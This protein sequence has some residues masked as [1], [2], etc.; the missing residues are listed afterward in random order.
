MAGAVNIILPLVFIFLIYTGAIL[1]IYFT[2]FYN[3]DHV[4]YQKC[5]APLGEF[6]VEPSTISSNIKSVCGANNNNQCVKQ[7]NNVE[8]AIKYCN[9]YSEICDRFMY[10]EQSK[11]VSIIDLKGNLSK[12]PLHNLYT[13]QVGITYDSPGLDKGAFAASGLQYVDTDIGDSIFTT[14]TVDSGSGG[15][16]SSG[17]GG[18]G[19]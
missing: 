1:V 17:G 12:S 5:N 15:G 9:L 2:T 19:Y 7:V 18:G 11:T 6:A 16:G 14:D 3:S 13:R 4:P 10:N 8:E